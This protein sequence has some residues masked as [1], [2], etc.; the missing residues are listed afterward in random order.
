MTTACNHSWGGWRSRPLKGWRMRFC[1]LSGC[2]HIE[3]LKGASKL[4]PPDSAPKT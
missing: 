1:K 2:V 3:A 4:G